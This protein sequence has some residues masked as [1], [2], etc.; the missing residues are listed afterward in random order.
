MTASS[1]ST[2]YC[3]LDHRCW[4]SFDLLVLWTSASLH[5]GAAADTVQGSP[6]KSC[7]TADIRVSRSRTACVWKRASRDR[8]QTS[9][10]ESVTPSTLLLRC[11]QACEHRRSGTSGYADIHPEVAYPDADSVIASYSSRLFGL[12]I[13][14]QYDTAEHV[15][16]LLADTG[17][18]LPAVM[19]DCYSMHTGALQRSGNVP[20]CAGCRRCV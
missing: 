14:R 16:I 15:N 6:W 7:S 20:G 4:A 2:G 1:D 19:Q 11:C 18:Q 17:R 10:M 13:C 5:H 12:P 9:V 3:G 8:K